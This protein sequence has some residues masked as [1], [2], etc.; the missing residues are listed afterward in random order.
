LGMVDAEQSVQLRVWGLAGWLWADLPRKVP[1]TGRVDELE[2]LLR[3]R[4]D[5][6]TRVLGEGVAALVRL[7]RGEHAQARAHAE[8]CA[9]LLEGIPPSAPVAAIGA[10][11]VVETCLALAAEGAS[12]ALELRK[13]ARRC[14]LAL[15]LIGFQNKAA[16]P[17]SLLA[18]GLVRKALGRTR[19]ARRCLRRCAAAAR[20]RRTRYVEAQAYLELALLPD[21]STAEHARLAHSLL[22]PL[23]APRELRRLPGQ[24][25]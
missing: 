4:L 8:S 5:P 6:G 21:A 23:D 22:Q 15:S 16:G 19:A 14:A 20:A 10:F 1:G 12:D 9:R 13:R 24:G 7:R 11:G 17:L 2:G 18:S 25:S 3:L